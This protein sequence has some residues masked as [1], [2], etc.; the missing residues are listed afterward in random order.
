MK[1]VISIFLSIIK[2]YDWK[3]FYR[4]RVL[5]Y[6]MLGMEI[7]KKV[8]IKSGVIIEYPQNIKI[9]NNVSIQH[10]CFLSG[11]GRIEIGNNVSI[12]HGVSIISSTHDYLKNQI[13]RRAPLI[14]GE[15]IIGDNV[16]IGMKVS[17]YYNL[18]IGQGVIIGSNSVVNKTIESNKIV[19]GVPCK[20]L[21]ERKI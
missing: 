13:I 9:G 12:A 6:K 4:I 15:V 21:K 17:I 7:G 1:K 19:G 11:Y 14:K 2:P 5:L 18:K 8:I 20:V 10:N 16:W 3:Y